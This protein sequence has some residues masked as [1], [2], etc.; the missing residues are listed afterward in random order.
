[1]PIGIGED[2]RTEPEH[3][4]TGANHRTRS[5]NRLLHHVAEHA[6]TKHLALSGEGD[7]FNRKNVAAHFRPGEAVHDADLRLALSNRDAEAANAEILLEVLF[8]DNDRKLK[9]L[10]LAGFEFRENDLAQDLADRALKRTHACFAGVVADDVA[11]RA[12]GD[13][14]FSFLHAVGAHLLGHEVPESNV[15][16]FVL[17]IAGERNHFHAVE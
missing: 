12:F 6:G 5:L 15:H 9:L 3:L 8:V 16:L 17:G 1:M 7:G 14:G 11:N 10:I 13:P 4:S 2:V